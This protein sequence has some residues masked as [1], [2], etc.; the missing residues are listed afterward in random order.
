MSITT[1]TTTT[2][3]QADTPAWVLVEVP[4]TGLYESQHSMHIEDAMAH[5]FTDD[6]GDLIAS[7]YDRADQLPF[8]YRTT[9]NAYAR[10][11][12]ATVMASLG[13]PDTDWFFEALDSPREY[14]FVSDRVFVKL[15][16][17]RAQS[18][19]T[20]VLTHL[21]SEFVRQCRD[22][23]TSRDGFC[24][25][26]DPD[27]TTWG[28][29]DTWDHNQFGALFVVYCRDVLDEDLDE[30]QSYY[31]T[32]NIDNMVDAG[33]AAAGSGDQWQALCLEAYNLRNG[34]E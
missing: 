1:T 32:D 7:L 25:W 12:A 5:P 34:A 33:Y 20:R 28:I 10:E 26:Y 2:T 27:Y 15:T 19:T 30:W 8:C 6:C 16:P 21:H 23:M 24:S 29:P 3:P 9:H 17:S 18:I 13:I 4:F 31:A 14:N 22:T 11:Y